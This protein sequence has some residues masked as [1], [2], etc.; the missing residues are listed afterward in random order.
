MHDDVLDSATLAGLND[1]AG[2]DDGFIPELFTMF[3]EQG[4]DIISRLTLA[5]DFQDRSDFARASHTLAG[6]SG[7]IAAV[8]LAD[9]CRTAEVRVRQSSDDLHSWRDRIASEYIRVADCARSMTANT[10]SAG[11]NDRS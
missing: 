4:D 7:N 6:S 1:L 11:P 9:L 2:D 5:A 3:V 8:R 10:S